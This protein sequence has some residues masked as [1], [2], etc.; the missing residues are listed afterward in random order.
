MAALV[1]TRRLSQEEHL[2]SDIVVD[3]PKASL[4]FV[5]VEWRA[6]DAGAGLRREFQDGPFEIHPR[7]RADKLYG[8]IQNKKVFS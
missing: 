7:T 6:I 5:Q 4:P 1:R 8:R 2:V 3:A